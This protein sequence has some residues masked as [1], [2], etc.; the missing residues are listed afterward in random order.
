MIYFNIKSNQSI[1]SGTGTDSEISKSSPISSKE[2]KSKDKD[3]KNNKGEESKNKDEAEDM[4]TYK[5]SE[6][7]F[8]EDIIHAN[9]E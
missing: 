9:E 4:F 2:S 5:C 7:T 6:S 1:I 3:K 8:L